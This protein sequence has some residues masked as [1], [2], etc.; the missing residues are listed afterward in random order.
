MLVPV[1]L[2]GTQVQRATLHNADYIARKDIRIG[3]TV[4]VR[5][6]AEIIPEI[7]SVDKSARTGKEIPYTMPKNCPA[8]G[9]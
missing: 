5:K 2:A 1:R 3:D 6:A 9:S 8:C 4:I 7:V